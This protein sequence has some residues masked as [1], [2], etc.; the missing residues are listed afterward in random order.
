MKAPLFTEQGER[1]G[2]VEIPD[3]VFGEEPNRHL[4]WE[5]ARMYTWNKRGSIPKIKSRG[6]IRGSGA[7]LWPE[8][9]LGR[10]R[11][12][13]RYAPIFVG[14]AKA[15]G[16]RGVK[17]VYSI[18]K[19]EKTKALASA[20]SNRAREGKI[21]VF[22]KLAFKEI[23]TKEFLGF[24]ERIGLE[25]EKILFLSK[26][27]NREFYRSGRNLR[28]VFFRTALDVNALDVLNCE[29]VGIEKEAISVIEERIR[30]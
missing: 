20:L 9:G 3:S 18:P 1:V 24:L 23:K 8:K 2:E 13:D 22:E 5:V 27:L 25:R 16:P 29:V 10:A 11:H 19:R 7:K 28:G 6:E 21:I 17:T 4:L 26:D 14:G 12:G 30:K 15:H